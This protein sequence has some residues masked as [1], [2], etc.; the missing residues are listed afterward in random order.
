[1]FLNPSPASIGT[2][3][4]VSA[5]KTILK[6]PVGMRLHSE[7]QILRSQSVSPGSGLVHSPRRAPIP[8]KHLV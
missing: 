4:P 1:M 2:V 6:Y 7:D 3:N 5:L 8:Y